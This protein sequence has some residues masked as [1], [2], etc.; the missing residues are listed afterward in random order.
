MPPAPLTQLGASF[1]QLHEWFLV[2]IKSG[3]TESQALELLKAILIKAQ[4]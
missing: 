1:V 2:A 3:F 4:S